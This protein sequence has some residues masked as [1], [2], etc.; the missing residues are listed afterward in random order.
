[1]SEDVKRE[2]IFFLISLHEGYEE[3]LYKADPSWIRSSDD[4]AQELWSV[5]HNSGNTPRTG[6]YMGIYNLTNSVVHE[7]IKILLNIILC[8]KIFYVK[9]LSVINESKFLVFII[10][11]YMHYYY[12]RKEN[13]GFM[14]FF[15]G[16][17]QDSCSSSHRGLLN[18]PIFSILFVH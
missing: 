2:S 16:F 3:Y 4:V 13:T 8:F 11:L 6:G 17:S 18:S 10:D 5:T 9:F 7:I 12:F 14:C 15:H 1:M